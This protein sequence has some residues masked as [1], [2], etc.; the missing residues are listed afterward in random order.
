MAVDF[1]YHYTGRSFI[2]DILED[3]TLW[4]SH[5]AWGFGVYLTDIPPRDDN[6]QRISTVFGRRRFYAERLEAYVRIDR[7]KADADQHPGDPHTF[8]AAGKVSLAGASV[9]VGVWQGGADERDTAGWRAAEFTRCAPDLEELRE[10]FELL[11][12]GPLD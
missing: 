4:P 11:R 10:A 12:M 2:D 1:L 5:A 7:D 9:T 6:R 3:C 8:I